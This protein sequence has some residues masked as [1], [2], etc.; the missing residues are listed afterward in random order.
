MRPFLRIKM[1]E[2]AQDEREIN[3][4]YDLNAWAVRSFS[5]VDNTKLGTPA[6]TLSR[7][8]MRLARNPGTEFADGDDH[9]G[10]TLTAPLTPEGML[11]EDEVRRLGA[12]RC[13]VR[14]FAPDE[15]A[16]EGRLSRRGKTW[17]FDYGDA[18]DAGEEPGYRLGQH[19]FAVGEYV[20]ITDEDGLLLT[21]KVTDVASTEV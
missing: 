20:S 19:R 10:Y 21:Y 1:V 3:Q 12:A 2:L 9:R 6:M 11:D 15:D 16:Q 13:A 7:I 4:L 18:G 17:F 5:Q 14:R 8:V